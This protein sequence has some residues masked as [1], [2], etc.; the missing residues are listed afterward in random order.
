MCNV[1]KKVADATN[2]LRANRI[3]CARSKDGGRGGGGV[4][5]TYLVRTCSRRSCSQ[6][7]TDQRILVKPIRDSQSY[8]FPVHRKET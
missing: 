1:K 7:Y 5:W 6:R 8:K 4:V 2:L 3:G